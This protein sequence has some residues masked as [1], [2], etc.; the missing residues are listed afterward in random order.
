LTLIELHVENPF[1]LNALPVSNE[2]EEFISLSE[3]ILIVTDNKHV[4]LGASEY[5]LGRGG[6]SDA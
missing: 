5:S 1:F 3:Y 2:V 4:N 6:E